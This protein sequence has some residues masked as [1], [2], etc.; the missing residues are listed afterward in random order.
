MLEQCL[1]IYVLDSRA[2]EMSTDD[3]HMHFGSS[4]SMMSSAASAS[5]D[6]DDHDD[7]LEKKQ[8]PNQRKD[9]AGKG[10]DIIISSALAE[11]S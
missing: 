10:N 9:V 3:E 8:A 5:N 6:N 7:D 1:S 11:L 4:S 2:Q